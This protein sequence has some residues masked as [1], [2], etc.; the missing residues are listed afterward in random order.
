MMIITESN[1]IKVMSAEHQVGVI[2][3]SHH[4]ELEFVFGEPNSNIM[5]DQ[6]FIPTAKDKVEKGRHLLIHGFYGTFI[7]DAIPESNCSIEENEI[8][9][10][11]GED[12]VSIPKSLLDLNN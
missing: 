11:V 12:K 8:I 4:S 10:S 1:Q 3:F 9:L 7:E 2:D 5:K 6:T